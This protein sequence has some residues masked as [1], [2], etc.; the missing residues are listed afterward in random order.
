MVLIDTIS[1]QVKGVLGNYNSREEER[2]S[3]KD[4]YTRPE[5]IRYKEKNYKVPGVLLSG[6]HKK[7]DCWKMGENR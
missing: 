2:V 3:G 5:I 6:D 7:I 4:V 1:R